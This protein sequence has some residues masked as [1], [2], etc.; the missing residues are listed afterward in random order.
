M[1]RSPAFNAPNVN[2]L[3]TPA[4]EARFSSGTPS[5]H[6]FLVLQ[7]TG[8]VP[9]SVKVE[10]FVR[11]VGDLGVFLLDSF[12]QLLGINRSLS[13]HVILSSKT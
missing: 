6:S 9:P 13:A 12:A 3:P 2:G 8:Q 5:S 10:A 7:Q 1:T 4:K 11:V